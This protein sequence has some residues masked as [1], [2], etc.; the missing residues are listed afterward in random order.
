MI[1]W[2]LKLHQNMTS[3]VAVKALFVPVP[4]TPS[5]IKIRKLFEVW[6]LFGLHFSLLGVSPFLS[7]DSD[8]YPK[9]IIVNKSKS[10]Q[11]FQKSQKLDC[12]RMTPDK[13]STGPNTIYTLPRGEV[14][15]EVKTGSLTTC[16]MC[17]SPQFRHIRSEEWFP[18]HMYNIS[19]TSS[20]ILEVH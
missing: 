7:K 6:A 16:T 8:P 12:L 2:P 18:H 1:L 9:L 10:N 14:C 5:F 17:T 19:V 20:D 11:W 13:R 3:S 4:K 15:R